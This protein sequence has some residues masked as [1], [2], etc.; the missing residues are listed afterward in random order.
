MLI[1]NKDMLSE[2]FCKMCTEIV[3]KFITYQKISEWNNREM[4]QKYEK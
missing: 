4:I 3:N 2:I 1:S